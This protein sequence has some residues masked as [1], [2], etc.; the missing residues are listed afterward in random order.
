MTKINNGRYGKFSRYNEVKV[1]AFIPEGTKHD[2]IHEVFKTLKEKF[3]LDVDCY[4]SAETRE[5]MGEQHFD[6]SFWNMDNN[7]DIRKINTYFEYVLVSSFNRVGE[8]KEEF[9]L[10]FDYENSKLTLTNS[11]GDN[12][13]FKVTDLQQEGYLMKTSKT[14]IKFRGGIKALYK[15]IINQMHI[16]S[17]DNLCNYAYGLNKKYIEGVK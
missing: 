5:E 2:S 14:M 15:E 1:L 8:R 3:H 17:C 13:V 6:M 12:K 16:G 10:K 7:K 4:Q 11:K 9:L